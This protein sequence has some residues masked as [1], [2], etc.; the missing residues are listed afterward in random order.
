MHLQII[1]IFAGKKK[2]LM[3]K[4]KYFKHFLKDKKV[5]SFTPT[6]PT[7]ISKICRSIKFEKDI[8]IVEYGAGTGV[9][10][11]EALKKMTP[12]SKIILIESN[13]AFYDY[14]KTLDDD[15]IICVHD[16]A[17]KILDILKQLNIDKVDY[18]VSGI[19]F[20]FFKEDQRDELIRISY[21]LLNENG[22]FFAYQLSPLIKKNLKS[23]FKEVNTHFRFS[24]FTPVF[25]MN[26]IKKNGKIHSKNITAD[27]E[28]L[29][30]YNSDSAQ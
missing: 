19:P 4:I 12:N 6:S 23:Y 22:A 8:T 21:E 20:S 28:E 5:A 15:R 18:I 25:I 1:I 14:L 11:K 30:K 16:Q 3:D 13:V 9:F 24:Y 2:G 27:A 10:T 17:E 7:C 26:G 29:Y